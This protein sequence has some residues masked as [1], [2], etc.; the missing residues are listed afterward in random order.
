MHIFAGDIY[1]IAGTNVECEVLGTEGSNITYGLPKSNDQCIITVSRKE[2]DE[3][4]EFIRR[5][6]V[7]GYYH[8]ENEYPEDKKAEDYGWEIQDRFEEQMDIAEY[9]E[10]KN[11]E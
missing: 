9:W 8:D 2:F 7:I 3:K 4:F 11:G 10:S 1:C 5:D 6:K